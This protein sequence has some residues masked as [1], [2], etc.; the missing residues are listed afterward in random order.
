MEKNLRE[1]QILFPL[2]RS[3]HSINFGYTAHRLGELTPVVD[4]NKGKA[5]KRHVD[6]DSLEE[7]EAIGGQSTTRRVGL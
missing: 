3:P 7:A 4:A 5:L 2:T 1:T 6:D